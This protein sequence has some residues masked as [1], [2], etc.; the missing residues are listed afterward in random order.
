MSQQQLKFV[1]MNKR[2]SQWKDTPKLV[3]QKHQLQMSVLDCAALFTLSV[4]VMAW[5]KST[6][7][8]KVEMMAE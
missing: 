1:H 8:L 2:I 5:E 6:G 3:Q 7:L 4:S